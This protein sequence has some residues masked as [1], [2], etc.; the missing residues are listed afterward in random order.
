MEEPKYDNL[1]ALYPEVN[2]VWKSPKQTTPEFAVYFWVKQ[3][4][5]GNLTGTGIKHPK[6]FLTESWCLLFV[7][8]VTGNDILL[9]FWTVA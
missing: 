6:E 1:V 3:W 7:P 9:H 8:G 4:I 2:G 5:V